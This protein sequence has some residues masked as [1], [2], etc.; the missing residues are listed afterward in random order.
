MFIYRADD[1]REPVLSRALQRRWHAVTI[2]GTATCCGAARA[3]KDKRYLSADAPRLPLAGCDAARCACRYA[4]FDDRR[5]G[6]RRADE[7][8]GAPSKPVA[9]D[10]RSRRGRRTSDHSQD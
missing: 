1:S 7:K 6:P 4:H 2:A 10:H 5:R 8:G 9:D 3:C